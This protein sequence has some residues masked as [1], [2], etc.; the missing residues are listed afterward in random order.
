MSNT[1]V[2]EQKAKSTIKE[3]RKDWCLFAREAL[4]AIL[5]D[6][7]AE[8]LRSVQNNPRTTVASG[9][10]RGKDFIA[11]VASV[12]FFYLTPRWDK[13]G[14]LIANTKVANTAPTGRQVINIMVP[15]IRKLIRKARQRGIELPG[16]FSGNDIRTDW[17][18]WFL[19]GFKADDNTHEAWS[20]FHAVNT[21][22]VVTEATGIPEGTF[23][24]IEGNLQGNSRLLIVFNP[25]ILTGYAARSQKKERWS[26]FSLSSLNATNVVEKK[27]VIPGQ[28]DYEWVLDKVNSW[29]EPIREDEF[30]IEH[31]DFEWEGQLY[32]PNDLFRKKVLGTFPKVGEDTLI[33]HQWIELAQKRWRD[34]KNYKTKEPARIGVDV[35]GMGRD[36]SVFCNRFDARVTDFYAMNSGGKAEHMKVAGMTKTR[37]EQNPGSIAFI[38]TIGEGA[39]VYSRL[40]EQG[41]TDQIYS[42]KFGNK[43]EDKFGNPLSDITGEYKFAN[44]RAFC[45]WGVRDWLDP[46]NETGAMLPEDVDLTE[47]ASEI[48]WMFQSNGSII[49]E[50]KDEIIKRLG[51]SP[52]KFDSLANTFAPHY[53]RKKQNLTQFFR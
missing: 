17:E 5:D 52:D 14:N 7:Q 8:I 49:I 13:E 10:S 11:A 34:N 50:K 6:E 35:A 39:G 37:L 43:A 53:H 4:G 41:L 31:D 21:M 3:W 9:T 27:I 48:K 42:V 33:P 24:A 16:R 51:R 44:M 25:N 12:C 26:R 15:E 29:A 30:N 23:E 28:V 32:R 40:D 46:K 45:F 2:I 47:E 36:K 1:A 19:T 18:E 22:F 20:G 38:D